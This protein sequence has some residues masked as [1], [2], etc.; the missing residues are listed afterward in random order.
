M[1]HIVRRRPEGRWQCIGCRA[2]FVSEGAAG[3]SR[4]PC[5]R[6]KLPHGPLRD[7]VIWPTV[8]RDRSCS[9]WNCEE[10]DP[11]HDFHGPGLYC[12]DMQCPCQAHACDC[13]V[14][15]MR[16]EAPGLNVLLDNHE[17]NGE[18]LLSSR[19][20]VQCK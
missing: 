11:S 15:E 8:G 18:W 1:G 17:G 6:V 20:N 19:D 4:F 13:D 2:A 5:P 3:V 14:C 10:P 12:D 9:A 7:H 16:I